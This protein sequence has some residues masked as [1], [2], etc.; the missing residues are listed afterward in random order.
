MTWQYEKTIDHEP[1]KPNLL[2]RFL[3]K[4]F[5]YSFFLGVLCAVIVSGMLAYA[6][7][8]WVPEVK[9]LQAGDIAQTTVLF[10]RTGQHVLYELFGEQNRKIIAHEDIPDSMRL[11]TLAA[12]DS[13]FYGHYGVDMTSVAR[14]VWVNIRREGK[15]QGGSTITMQL[16]RNLFLSRDKTWKR[17]GIEVLTAVKM[18]NQFTK[19]EILDWYLNVIPYG[20][21]AY[22]IEAASQTFFGKP[23]RDLSVDESA[24]LAGLPKA[25]TNYS[26]YGG[27]IERLRTR[28]KSILSR[29]KALGYI[30]NAS[31]RE[32]ISMDTLA[33]IRPVSRTIL[34]PHFVF[35]VLDELE[36]TYGKEWLEEGGMKIYTTLDWE[37]QQLAE[38]KVREGVQNNIWSGATN[39]ALVSIDPKTGDV[40]AMVG[41]RDYFD[42]TID[43]QVNVAVRLR[44]PGSSFKPLVYAQAFERGFQPET[45]LFDAP[46]N[47][48]PDGS[49]KDYV[50]QNYNLRFNGLVSMRQ[51][52]A[53]SLNIP[54]VKALYL[55]GVDETVELAKRLG[56]TT[57]SNTKKFGLSFALGSHEVTLLDET[58]AF[59]VFAN[60]GVRNPA[61]GISKILKNGDQEVTKP[62]PRPGQILS[63]ESA[64]K[65]NSIMS[66]DSARSMVFGKGTPLTI[67]GRTVA[68][69]S[70][71]TQDFHDGWT[72]GYSPYLATGVW[73][74]NNNNAA[75]RE[76]SDGVRV[77]APIWNSFM[78][79]A[80]LRYPDVPFPTY[81]KLDSSIPLVSSDIPRKIIYYNKNSGKKI[82]ESKASKK[83]AEDVR[84]KMEPEMHDLLY[85]LHYAS[86]EDETFPRYEEDMVFRWEKGIGN[87]ILTSQQP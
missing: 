5:V 7:S 21:N 71:T 50:P 40:L 54:A 12:E 32:A 62:R 35:Y 69:K 18:E 52:L 63:T 36:K 70:G 23:A 64:R 22:G 44:Q 84:I 19:D 73:V 24:L 41:S 28:Q 6:Y 77:A 4:F 9:Y 51:S 45:M 25:T 59:S 78:V 66:D 38:K 33:K 37:L 17:K 83:N 31:Y 65:V 27:N 20:S 80:L 15:A 68:A 16:A 46:T 67:S 60:D 58:A 57:L 85:Y 30:D 74:G 3:K 76:G 55:G 26:P 86:E 48:G 39:A 8:Q 14:A 56:I 49:G 47:F 75:L 72:V 79:E 2:W 11:A 43:G 81:T 82:S 42:K 13:G 53:N 34:A 87:N 29:M 61:T 1:P 10:D